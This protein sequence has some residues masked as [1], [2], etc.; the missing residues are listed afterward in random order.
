MKLR[1]GAHVVDLRTRLHCLSLPEDLQDVLELF[2]L[3]RDQEYP[4]TC[5]LN[6]E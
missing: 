1:G 2:T 3:W 4:C 5:A 6:L